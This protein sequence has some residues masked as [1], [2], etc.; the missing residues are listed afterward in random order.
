MQTIRE[1]QN[2]STRWL[3]T[4]ANT[5]ARLNCY[6]NLDTQSWAQK[7]R[8]DT[9]AT[10]LHLCRHFQKVGCDTKFMYTICEDPER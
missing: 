8:K 4:Q 10:A 5:S 3:V 1:A 7:G 2:I 9:K 6:H